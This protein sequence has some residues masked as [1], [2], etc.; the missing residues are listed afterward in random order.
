MYV[1]AIERRRETGIRM[2]VGA[3]RANIRRLFLV[4]AI[5]LTLFGGLL[6]ILVGVA[7]ASILLP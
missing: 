6:G 3:R 5:I 1:S 7:I 4:E 2:A